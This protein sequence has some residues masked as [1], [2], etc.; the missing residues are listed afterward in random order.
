MTM[1]IGDR[2]ELP[3]DTSLIGT[4]RAD[5]GCTLSKGLP[6][7]IEIQSSQTLHLDIDI[8]TGIR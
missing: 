3:P 7:S 4:A 8:D 5:D 2:T 1:P 6:Q